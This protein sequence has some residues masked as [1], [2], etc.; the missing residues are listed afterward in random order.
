MRRAVLVFVAPLVES[1]GELQAC[2]CLKCDS[3]KT[4][5]ALA[6][7]FCSSGSPAAID[8]S[9]AVVECLVR[10]RN[11]WDMATLSNLQDSMACAGALR[12]LAADHGVR[13]IEETARRS[14]FIELDG[15]F[16]AYWTTHF[17]S[18][19]RNNVRRRL[20][21]LTERPDC[22]VVC[23]SRPEE[24][25][26]GLDLL[27]RVSKASWKGRTTGTWQA[28]KPERRSMSDSPVIWQVRT[29]TDLAIGAGRIPQCS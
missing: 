28:Q 3:W 21:I 2:A 8:A 12:G 23:F 5:L 27:F 9:N 11:E 17:N 19:Q 20:K 24:M 29:C 1:S 15:N 10:H 18:K 22:R 4:A 26:G 25:P 16:A 7:A 13:V 6:T 14:P